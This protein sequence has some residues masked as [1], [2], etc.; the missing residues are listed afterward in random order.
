MRG[1]PNSWMAPDRIAWAMLL[2]DSFHHWLGRDLIERTGSAVQQAQRLFDAPF[3]V[4]SHGTEPD[5]VLNYGNRAAL[6]LWEMDWEELCRTPSRLTAEP[7]N[8]AERAKMLEA[9]AVR[10]AIEDYRG[11]RISKTGRRFRV[12]EAVVWNV[13]DSRHCLVGQ[14]ATFSRW[15]YVDRQ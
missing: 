8:Q 7:V 3:I 10:G 12:E 13:V 5:P 2:L 11:I 9:A 4:V 6:A 1:D 14:A 15:R